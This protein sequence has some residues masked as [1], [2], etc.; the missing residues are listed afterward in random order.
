MKSAKDT[1]S[2]ALKA[3]R[4]RL[5]GWK[6]PPQ[7]GHATLVDF[8]PSAWTLLRKAE[9]RRTKGSRTNRNL[10][11]FFSLIFMRC[12][13]TL[14]KAP[15]LV[16]GQVGAGVVHASG[17]QRRGRRARRTREALGSGRSPASSWC[18]PP[19]AM[20]QRMTPVSGPR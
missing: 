12:L 14:Q 16:E 3:S 8:L 11:Y 7:H 19:W 17:E 6:E 20:E 2:W 10:V 18:R 5:A 4:L 15:E 9:M 13:R 1:L